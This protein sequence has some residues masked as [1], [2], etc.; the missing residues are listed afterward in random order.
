MR[1]TA[2]GLRRYLGVCCLLLGA[3]IAIGANAHAKGGKAEPADKTSQP[4]PQPATSVTPHAEIKVALTDKIK[5]IPPRPALYDQNV[6][7]LTMQQCAQCHIAVFNRLKAEG[8]RHQKECTFCHEVYHTYAPGKVEYADA[9]PKCV[10]CHGY[11]HGEK[12]ETKTCHNCHS[13]A[14]SPLNIPSVK[15]DMCH[16]CHA[17]PPKDL[18]DFP[19]KHSAMA[20]TDCHIRHGYI[21]S[22]LDCHSPKGGKPYHLL[23]VEPKVCLSCHASPHK[24]LVIKYAADTPKEYCANCHKN[25]THAEVY[26]TLKKANSKHW[27]ENTCATCHDQHGKIPS[28]FKCHD[29]SGH[30]ANLKDDDCLRCHSNPHDPLNITFT[31]NEPKEICGGCHTDEYKTLMASKS[32][33]A[34]QTCS[35]CHPKHGQIPTCQKCHGNPHGEAMVAQFGGKCAS[36]HGTAHAVKGRVK[37]GKSADLT[38]EGLKGKLAFPPKK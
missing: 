31:P 38:A 2:Q 35:F 33:H 1:K 32:R 22:C 21:P 37:E 12:E 14:H 27:T 26:A 13:N 6:T 17:Q 11:P 8:H 19:S 23:N 4:Q 25:P 28:C 29:H 36:C 34:N 18:K 9:L 24:P 7:P 5:S 30:R 16:N 15:P 3:M 10:D 20:C